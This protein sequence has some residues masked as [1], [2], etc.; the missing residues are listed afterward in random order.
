VD[1]NSQW[2]ISLDDI[3]LPGLPDTTARLIAALE[4]DFCS[5]GQLEE[6]ILRDPALTAEVLRIVNA[7]YY[8]S[9]R[10]DAAISSVADTIMFI[11]IENLVTLVSIA[12]LTNLCSSTNLDRELVRHLIAVSSTTAVLTKQT[13]KIHI[14]REV[15]VV[16]GL[17]HDIGVIVLLERLQ[18]RYAS[19]RT[20][21]FENREPLVIAEQQ[22]LGFTHCTIGALLA[23]RWH[24][25]AI[26]RTVL[27]SH[28]D[29]VIPETISEISA[30][31]LLVQLADKL[32]IDAG[33]GFEIPTEIDES[34]ICHALGI[35]ESSLK[36]VKE[37]VLSMTDF[38]I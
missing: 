22:A 29:P 35:E 5:I 11:G 1:N 31:C 9:G 20:R 4:D 34:Q 2:M 19:I 27:G 6:I 17:L 32:A 25:P 18:Q 10:S 36:Q 8:Q 23:E 16:A 28:H 15:A 26:Y 12:S 21:A 24:F 30:I 3:Q 14:R 7:P 13:D 38:N 37:H 33:I